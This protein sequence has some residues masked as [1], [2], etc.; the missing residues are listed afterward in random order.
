MKSRLAPLLGALF[1]VS[2]L[3]AGVAAAEVQA[4]PAA[5]AS[6]QPPA[7][8][9]LGPMLELLRKKQIIS[10]AEAKTLLLVEGSEGQTR[11]LVELLKS[12][13]VISEAEAA[14]VAAPAPGAA[15]AV[16]A[17]GEKVLPPSQ[18]PKFIAQLRKVWVKNKNRGKDFDAWF[19]GVSDP[20]EILGRMRVMGALS[21]TEAEELERQYRDHY[22][23]GAISAALQT[24]EQDYLER[25]RKGVSWELDEK[26]REKTKGDWSQRVRV[27]GDFRL[28]YEQDF[29]DA[30][31]GDFLSPSNP[32]QLMNSK[33]DRQALKLRARLAVE[34]KLSDD[35]QAGIGLATDT[36]R[37][38]GSPISTNATLGDSFNKK[39]FALDKAFLKWSPDPA[40][41]LWAGRFANPWLST[42]LVWDQDVNFD[43]LALQ[44]RPQLSS[45]WGLFLGTG[46]FPVQ[47]VEL[48]Q[49][50]KWL[51]GSQIGVQYGSTEGMSAK[52]AVAYYNFMNTVGQ[53]N[54]PAQPGVKDWTAP[55]FQQKGNTLMDIDPGAAIKTA[56][57]SAFRELNLTG[58]LDLGYWQPVHVVLSADYVKNLGFNQKDVDL[59]TGSSVKKE[60]EGFQVGLSVGHPQTLELGDWKGVFSYKYLESD[61]VMDAFTDS[62]FHLGGTNSRG[63]IA[64][65]DLGLAKDVWLSTRWFSAN[66]ISGPPLAI[67][68]LHVNLNAKF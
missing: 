57:A 65:L 9:G 39:A 66:E 43:G 18:D 38:P 7:A 31:N 34:A 50:D 21:A 6:S 14:Q 13:G 12:K 59:R 22:L 48:A 23:T 42:D 27:G 68:V 16:M 17:V 58:S 26:I 30:G 51:F 19:A 63:W 56:Y 61:A 25:V 36:N 20:E 67:D 10:D 53:V 60:T 62:D 41:T 8:S 52:L 35:F 49:H 33:V 3:A 24:K 5:S 28:R 4:A 2:S 54:D 29:F 1:L 44:Y 47:E 64:G 55:A 15:P 40:L 37:S 46:I 45:N 11:T 32:A